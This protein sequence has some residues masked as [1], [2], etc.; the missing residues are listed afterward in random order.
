MCAELCRAGN[1]GQV[2]GYSYL[3]VGG[4][5]PSLCYPEYRAL[6]QKSA[7]EAINS[8]VGRASVQN[9]APPGA[10]GLASETWDLIALGH[11]ILCPSR[12][13]ESGEMNWKPAVHSHG[14]A[15]NYRL[16]AHNHCSMSIK[17]NSAQAH[18][19]ETKNCPITPRSEE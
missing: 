18:A 9:H 6:A 15:E 13:A 16:S 12:C 14:F 3:G 19:S 11:S 1:L 17:T 5:T 4:I 8:K 7:I 10:L 2:V